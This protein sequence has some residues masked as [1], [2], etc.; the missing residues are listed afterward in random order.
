MTKASA[1]P[2]HQKNTV[3]QIFKA[4]ALKKGI[5]NLKKGRL[6][7]HLVCFEQ[8]TEMRIKYLLAHV[9]FARLVRQYRKAMAKNRRW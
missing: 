8:E 3:C 5:E 7:D 1:L 4:W 6:K 2:L 9:L